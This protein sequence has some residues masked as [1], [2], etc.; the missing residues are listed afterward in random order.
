MSYFQPIS[1]A[2]EGVF[3]FDIPHFQDERGSFTKLYHEQITNIQDFNAFQIKELYYSFSSKGAVRGMHFQTPPAQHAKIVTCPK[4]GIQDV[5]LDLRKKS[6]TYGRYI[7]LELNEQSG[8]AIYIPEGCAHGFQSLEE[9]S[10]TLYLVS[11]VHDPERD[12]GIHYDSFG[13]KWPLPITSIS[14]RDSNFPLFKDW[15]TPF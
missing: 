9:H 3:I 10:M 5:I 13:M 8:K 11:S 2:L 15:A 6:T 12:E 1:T 4:G 7:T 14:K